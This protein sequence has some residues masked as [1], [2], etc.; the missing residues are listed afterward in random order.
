KSTCTERRI[1][2]SIGFKSNKYNRIITCIR[3]KNY[4]IIW[5]NN[6]SGTIGAAGIDIIRYINL[7]IYTVGA[8][9]CSISFIT[10]KENC[11]VVRQTTCDEFIV[12]LYDYVVCNLE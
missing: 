10:R 8:V 3:G 9:K 6:H 7:A 5:L 1:R 11:V 4:F 12:G 2:S